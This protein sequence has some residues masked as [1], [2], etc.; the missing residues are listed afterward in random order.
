MVSEIWGESDY[1]V[2]RTSDLSFSPE[3]ELTPDW[4]LQAVLNTNEKIKEMQDFT[5]V[6]GKSLLDVLGLTN[7]SG[8]IGE[9]F[10]CYLAAID[11][12]LINNEWEKGRPDLCAIDQRGREFLTH[13]GYFLED[14]NNVDETYEATKPHWSPFGG[15]SNPLNGVEVKCRIAGRSED[16]RAKYAS[17]WPSNKSGDISWSSHHQDTGTLLGL[18]W[19]YIEEIP[20]IIAAFF[21]NDLDT[22]AGSENTD[23]RVSTNPNKDKKKKR[24]GTSVS[25]MKPEGRKK[26]GSGP[27]LLPKDES[28]REAIN[29]GLYFQ[30]PLDAM[31]R[32]ELIEIFISRGLTGHSGKTA[33]QLRSLINQD[34]ARNESKNIPDVWPEGG[35]EE[36]NNIVKGIIREQKGFEAKSS[37]SENILCLL[38]IVEG[39][40]KP[41]FSKNRDSIRHWK[42][43]GLENYH[44]GQDD[45]DLNPYEESQ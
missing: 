38:D 41:E 8:L 29:P 5:V 30:Q 45:P 1:E 34:D 28:I 26:M 4:V 33:P 42:N 23:W 24:T 15:E 21:S 6:P 36:A 7:T 19:D 13:I 22:T 35:Q 31:G 3:M 14:G 12:R 43:L 2:I 20:T 18:V 10:S 11:E 17:R 25:G 37:F 16:G 40:G 44:P 27:V 32:P 9:I 39:G